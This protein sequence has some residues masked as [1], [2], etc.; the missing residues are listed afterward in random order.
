MKKIR[1]HESH[2]VSPREADIS[3]K[4]ALKVRQ[5]KNL[6]SA[7]QA[8]HA[9][10]FEIHKDDAVPVIAGAQAHSSAT[11]GSVD[12]N[13]TR[14][15]T[16]NTHAGPVDGNALIVVFWEQKLRKPKRTRGHAPLMQGPHSA[17]KTID[18]RALRFKVAGGTKAL[19][20]LVKRRTRN[21]LERREAQRT[22]R[23]MNTLQEP[24]R[25]RCHEP[26]RTNSMRY[27]VGAPCG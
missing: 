5:Q 2:A 1:P 12:T 4:L 19:A 22:R 7:A 9:N 20:H 14:T 8:T 6:F 25:T 10:R 3:C 23:R 11:T 17:S 27:V 18:E 26:K 13:A 21:K 24:K 16:A 15:N